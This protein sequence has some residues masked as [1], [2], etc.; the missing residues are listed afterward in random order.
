MEKAHTCNED[1]EA[2]DEFRQDKWVLQLVKHAMS[3]SMSLK[4]ETS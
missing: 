4:N 3:M 2:I 1:R